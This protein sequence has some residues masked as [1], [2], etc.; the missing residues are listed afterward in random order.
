MIDLGRWPPATLRRLNLRLFDDPQYQYAL[1]SIAGFAP[2]E[3]TRRRIANMKDAKIRRL[4]RA[5]PKCK[6]GHE[7]ALRDWW[8]AWMPIAAG[9]QLWPDGNHRVGMMWRNSWRSRLVSPS[10]WTSPASSR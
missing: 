2:E 9:R 3:V 10:S 8:A 5:A 4:L 1:D 7:A 6:V